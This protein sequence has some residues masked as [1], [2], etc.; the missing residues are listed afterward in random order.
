[1]QRE[2]K[3]TRKPFDWLLQ[4]EQKTLDILLGRL[5]WGLSMIKLPWMPEMLRVEWA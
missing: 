1:M 4:V 2:G 3:L 5:P